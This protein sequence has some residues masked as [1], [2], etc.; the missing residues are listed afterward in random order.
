MS[1]QEELDHKID[2][3]NSV[4][5]ASS[6]SALV[7]FFGTL[8]LIIVQLVSIQHQI[9]NAL[10]ANKQTI[11]AEHKKTQQY[12]KCVASTQLLPLSDRSKEMF[13]KCGID[14]D[15]PESSKSSN[16]STRQSSSPSVQAQPQVYGT[17][18]DQGSQQSVSPQQ[19]SQPQQPAPTSPQNPGTPSQPNDN[20]PIISIQVPQ[21]QSIL[22]QLIK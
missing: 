14:V 3:A 9:E 1:R 12:I 18:S 15:E 21:P 10:E 22:D 16:G 4:I 6:I 19:T 8:I 5:K 11:V 13:D 20:R 7:I 2:N 17:Q